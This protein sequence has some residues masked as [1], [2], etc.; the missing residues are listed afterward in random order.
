MINGNVIT[1]AAGAALLAKTRVK[2]SGVTV[3]NAGDE[4]SAIGVVEYDV[5]SG[6]LAAVRL[7]NAGG[8]FECVAGTAITA[9]AAVYA[10]ADGELSATGTAAKGF[11]LAAAT[12]DGDIIEC[13]LTA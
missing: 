10:A 7:I 12:A 2:L 11:A 13:L 3:V 1:L 6:E 9:G 4:E 5:A 8:T